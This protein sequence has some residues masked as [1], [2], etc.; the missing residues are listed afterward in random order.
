MFLLF[1]LSGGFYH[2][3]LLNFVKGFF[4]IHWNNHMV[5]IFQ[6]V[7]VVYHIDWFTNIEESLQS[8]DKAHLVMMYDFFLI[9]CWICLLEFCWGFLHLCPISDTDLYFSFSVASFS[10]FGIM[11]SI[12]YILIPWTMSWALGS[13]H[14]H[15][16]LSCTT[17][18]IYEF[19]QVAQ[20]SPY[21][22][23][24]CLAITLSLALF[25]AF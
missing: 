12:L 21:L 24:T 1:L 16:S 22:T 4:C 23:N 17:N 10:D 14:L 25:D 9:C 6:F 18:Y 2:K 7:N 3:W 19:I 15:L 20:S 11:V 8:W 13:Y 5:F